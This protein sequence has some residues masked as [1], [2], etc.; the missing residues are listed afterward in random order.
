MNMQKE[1][2]MKNMKLSED[3]LFDEGKEKK[4]EGMPKSVMFS[5]FLV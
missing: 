4:K 5:F 1:G 2:K 3:E